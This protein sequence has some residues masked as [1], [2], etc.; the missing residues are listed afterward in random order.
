MPAGHFQQTVRDSPKTP[1]A[2]SFVLKLVSLKGPMSLERRI[3]PPSTE[4]LPDGDARPLAHRE[5]RLGR[6]YEPRSP[7]S[8]TARGT[9]TTGA[10]RW[11]LTTKGISPAS[12]VQVHTG[13]QSSSQLDSDRSDSSRSRSSY[14]LKEE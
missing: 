12:R 9:C 2:L 10:T 13:S 8:P 1:S 5:D 11:S 3:G 14:R 4:P 6:F 7:R